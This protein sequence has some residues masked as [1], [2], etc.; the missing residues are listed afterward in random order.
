M[1]KIKKLLPGIL[2]LFCTIIASAQSDR[3]AIKDI[4]ESAK[5]SGAIFERAEV[6][7]PVGHEIGFLKDYTTFAYNKEAFQHLFSSGQ[8]YI[9]LSLPIKGKVVEVHLVRREILMDGFL[10]TH[11]EDKNIFKDNDKI[12]DRDLGLHY[13][14]YVVGEEST[15]I[16]SVSMFEDQMFGII[17]SGSLNNITIHRLTDK[18]H[19][20]IHIAYFGDDVPSE[21]GGKVI[22]NPCGIR[23]NAYGADPK[24]KLQ[25]LKEKIKL[26]QASEST[27]K[28]TGSPTFNDVRCV[29]YFLEVDHSMYTMN[30]SDL[31]QTRQVVLALFAQSA[32]L[33][34]YEGIFIKL[35]HM[36]VWTAFSPYTGIDMDAQLNTFNS[37]WGSGYFGDVAMLIDAHFNGGLAPL[38]DFG[39]FCD[40]LENRMGYAGGPTSVTNAN[41][42]YNWLFFNFNRRIY[43][44]CHESGHI[45]GSHHTHDCVWGTG[46]SNAIDGCGPALACGPGCN[47]SPGGCTILPP[48]SP[49]TIM[50]YCDVVTSV[51]FSLGFGSE[52]G[53]RIHFLVTGVDC[54]GECTFSCPYSYSFYPNSSFFNTVFTPTF[55]RTWA[56]Q[57]F[58]YSKAQYN[59]TSGTGNLE[60]F[61]GRYVMLDRGMA[62]QPGFLADV[63][64]GSYFLA[65]IKSCEPDAFLPTENFTIEKNAYSNN[66]TSPVSHVMN[67]N[68]V[69]VYPNPTSGS[70]TVQVPQ[71]GVYQLNVTNMLGEVVYRSEIEN[72]RKK[73]IQ[74]DQAL[75]SGNYTIHINGGN[76]RH[77]QK[78]TIL[79]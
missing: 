29:K 3:N 40:D 2:L 35:S 15:S 13:F 72:D 55:I 47:P 58:I 26:H 18:A 28:S 38:N 20:D 8:A 64:G 57:H 33:F 10:L 60:Y 14:G 63:S 71:K 68:G 30:G 9:S 49:G 69:S 75:P 24:E 39:S 77:V 79:K 70:F 34:M 54:L 21:L 11:S 46:S 65:E 17:S 19:D 52:P 62:G 48:A 23:K 43:I 61:A 31:N 41:L 5:R 4:V 73:E 27:N 56:A 7:R 12:D 16:A 25:Q 76:L 42:G 53:F 36:N 50:S 74:L 67:A 44:F 51:N 78:L 6:F 32:S 66:A 37:I 59:I 1:K 22:E 45:F